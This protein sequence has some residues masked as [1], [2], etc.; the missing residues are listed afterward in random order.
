[1]AVA[2]LRN[3]GGVPFL[4]LQGFFVVR[5]NQQPDGDTIAFAARRPFD[6]GPVT[7]PAPVDPS[8]ATT[9]NIRFQ[10]IDAPEKAQ[11]LGA[12]GRDAALASLGIDPAE[13]GLDD[14]DFTAAGDT[15][16]VPGWVATHGVDNR[17]RLL[18]YLFVDNPGFRHGR[19]VSAADIRDV[20]EQSVNFAQV[21]SGAAFPAFYE[22]TDETHAVIFAEAA[23]EARRRRRGVWR[24]D[25]TTIAFTP[26][27]DAL[28]ADGALVYPK[29][30]RRVDK[31][32]AA[33]PDAEAFITWLKGQSDGKKLVQGAARDPV[34]LWRLFE[35]A[36]GSE[37]RVPYDVTRLWFSE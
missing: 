33:R 19:I 3:V 30:F 11:P 15:V 14:T 5:Q 20:L 7:A 22:N 8:G 16:L 34:P 13:L 17:D 25:R 1:M 4:T 21:E 36:S 12:A 24:H 37:V 32:K 35:P 2:P 29:F 28:H 6:P 26:V 9:I 18:G 10:S 31:W 27:P 23:T